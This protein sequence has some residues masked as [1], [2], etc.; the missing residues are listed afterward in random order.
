MMRNGLSEAHIVVQ[1]ESVNQ[2]NANVLGPTKT[3]DTTIKQS[4]RGKCK[5]IS[6][7]KKLNLQLLN[8]MN[9]LRKTQKTGLTGCLEMDF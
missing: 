7:K 6:G 8:L 3:Q 2:T 4:S 9:V 1:D 5:S